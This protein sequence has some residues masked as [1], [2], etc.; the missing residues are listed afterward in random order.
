MIVKRPVLTDRRQRA[1]ALARLWK[2]WGSGPEKG[3]FFNGP[4]TVSNSHAPLGDVSALPA[5]PG[6]RLRPQV[7]QGSFLSRHSCSYPR[8]KL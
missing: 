7:L 1:E 3:R 6:K 5:T 2:F 8:H 4:E